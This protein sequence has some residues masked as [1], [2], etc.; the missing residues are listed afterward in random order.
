MS[1]GLVWRRRTLSN[2][3]TVLLYPRTSSNTA[4]LSA[5]VKYGSIQE[6][7]EQAGTAHFLEHMLA[8]GSDKRIQLSRSIEGSGGVL[9]FYTDREYVLGTVDVLPHRLFEASAILS[10]LFFGNAFD[11][12]KFVNEQKI[13]LHELAEAADDPATRTQE[14]L[15]EG[16]FKKHPV[17]RPVG[18]YTET[19]KKLNLEGLKREH[20][21]N[22]VPQNT[23]LVLTGN[24]TEKNA[25]EALSNF[26]D[27]EGNG[28]RSK[29]TYPTETFMPKSVVEE[30]AGLTQTY[31][32]VGARTV[33]SSHQDTPA[34]DLISIL[35]AGGTSSR[36]FIELREKHAVTYDVDCTH[37]KGFSFGYF[38]INC[39]ANSK[40]A[41][42]TQSLILQELA[43]LRSEPVSDGELERAKQ[44]MLG[45]VLRGMD[46]P[47]TVLDILTFIEIQ[48]GDEHALESY[49]AERKAL[50]SADI[51]KV[52]NKY[53]S[54]DCLCMARLEP[55]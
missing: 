18:G 20:Q 5:A 52:A 32:S 12:Q 8:G 34:L 4:Q 54:Q 9:D 19:V 16:L 49:L 46:N 39:A 26:V 47:E 24:F 45:G 13:I 15:L 21:A 55:K 17:R 51:Q 28:N 31:I 44:I 23:V 7:P 35:L 6:P 37:S 10:E 42:K 1:N 50:T 29:K 25:M 36:L 41:E 22:Y 33:C 27:K 2:G 14:M 30:K 43:K 3:L 11:E 48:F 53:L 38:S 40:T